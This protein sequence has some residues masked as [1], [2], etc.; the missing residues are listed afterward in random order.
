MGRVDEAG[1]HCDRAFELSPLEPLRLI[2]HSVRAEASLMQDDPRAAL[3]EAHRGRA[4]NPGLAQL[5]AFGVAAS[6]RVE[7]VAKARDWVG[8]LLEHKAFQSLAAVRTT[9]RPPTSQ[10][11]WA[12]SSGCWKGCARPGCR[13]SGSTRRA[14]RSAPCWPAP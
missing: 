7:A 8:V 2:C 6:L 12:I 10:P 1:A 14:G 3:D 4:V 5:Y 11:L 9:C 13:S